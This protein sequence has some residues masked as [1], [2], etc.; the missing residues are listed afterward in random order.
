MVNVDHVR[1]E[2]AQKLGQIR[3]DAIEVDLA[4]EEAI[5]MT[6]PQQHLVALRANRLEARAW[7][8]LPM[9][10]VG[11][12]EEEYFMAGALIG[13]EEVVRENLRT[14]RME[15]RMIV[16]RDQNALLH[17]FAPRRSATKTSW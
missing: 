2:I 7:A 1:L 8:H 11:S 14:A 13:A 6:R 12:A 15:S 4:H 16:R 3:N 10:L 9:G 5:E 17:P